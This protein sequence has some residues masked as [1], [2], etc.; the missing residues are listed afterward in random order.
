MWWRCISKAC[1]NDEGELAKS[2]ADR[3][4]GDFDNLFDSESDKWHEDCVSEALRDGNGTDTV[5]TS[6]GSSKFS[7]RGVKLKSTF[8]SNMSDVSTCVATSTD[9]GFKN[10]P[11]DQPRLGV[12]VPSLRTIFGTT[13]LLALCIFLFFDA[14]LSPADISSKASHTQSLQQVSNILLSTSVHATNIQQSDTEFNQKQVYNTITWTK[15]WGGFSLRLLAL[16]IIYLHKQTKQNNST[17]L[18]LT[19]T[20]KQNPS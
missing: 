9:T 5:S 13:K 11:R 20:M 2:V 16:S 15:V 7:C 3:G 4:E 17:K 12:C 6:V 14:E 10:R 19:Q 8:C 18:H 1:D